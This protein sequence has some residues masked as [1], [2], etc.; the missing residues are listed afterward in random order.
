MKSRLITLI[1]F[2]LILVSCELDSNLFNPKEVNSYE[3]PGNTIPA[4]LVEE[5]QLDS[6]GNKIYGFWVSS[7]GERP[8]ITIL[9]CHGNKH[10][11]DEYWDRVMLFYE[12]GVNVF[13]FDYRGYGKSEGESSEAGLFADSEAALEYVKSRPE[14]D[15]D[16]LCFYGYSLGNVASIYLAA[17]IQDPLCLFSEAPFA[18][19]NS[20]T[21]GSMVL[22]IQPR[23]LTD[24][25]FDNVGNIKKVNAPFMLL[26]GEDDDFVRFRDN[27]Q[28]VYNAAPNPKELA[29]VAN[30]VHNNVPYVLGKDNYFNKLKNW[31]DFSIGK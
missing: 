11:I 4:N 10:N 9:Y 20:L 27:G 17:K 13:I 6:E 21:Q 28:V 24:G 5:V 12:L 2:G 25:E 16:S 19:V 1:I 7:N 23:W 15:S 31:I 29:L 3:L 8:G 26:H 18:S 30:A 14:Y 22:D